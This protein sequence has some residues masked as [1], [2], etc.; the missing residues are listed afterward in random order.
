MQE[1]VRFGPHVGMYPDAFSPVRGDEEYTWWLNPQLI[2]LNTFELAG[3]P[4][5]L[6]AV[7][8]RSRWGALHV[9]SG[10]VIEDAGQTRGRVRLSL[11]GQPG[12]TSTTLIGGI[13]RPN[14]IEADGRALPE[15][16]DLDAA[17]EG[18][19]WLDAHRVAAVKVAFA[20][21]VATVTCH[22]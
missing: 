6:A 11:Q 12:A 19:R 5:D 7:V 22:L 8:L 10:A 18:W 20:D 2:G 4:V 13:E 15:V 9:A 1:Q 21:A 17:T 3:L 16:A 14:G